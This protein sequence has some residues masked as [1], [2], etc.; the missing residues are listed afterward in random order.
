MHI[1]EISCDP[2][3]GMNNIKVIYLKYSL[4]LRDGLIKTVPR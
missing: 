4:S 3:H 1:S 2:I